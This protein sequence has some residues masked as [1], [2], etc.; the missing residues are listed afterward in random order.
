MYSTNK[1]ISNK[2][3]TINS[4]AVC[5]KYLQYPDETSK[6]QA[7]GGLRLKGQYKQTLKDKPLITVITVVYNNEDTLERCIKSVLEQTYDNIEYIVID[8]GSNDGTLNIIK[9]YEDSIDYFISEP[10]GGI[11]YAMNKG[12]SLVSG[13]YIN[14]MNSDDWF[15]E[16]LTISSI[17]KSTV[18]DLNTIYYGKIMYVKEGKEYRESWEQLVDANIL[19]GYPIPHQSAFVGRNVFNT[20]GIFDTKYKISADF[21]W[22]VKA[23][24]NK[25]SFYNMHCIVANYSIEGISSSDDGWDTGQIEYMYILLINKIIEPKDLLSPKLKFFDSFKN[26]DKDSIIQDLAHINLSKD[27]TALIEECTRPIISIIIPVYNMEIYIQDCLDSLIEQSI[28]NRLEIIIVDDTSTD[29]SVEIINQYTDTYSAITLIKHNTNLGALAARYTGIQQAQGKYFIF[30]DSDDLM[31]ADACEI[32]Y[33]EIESKNADIV[34]GKM[35]WKFDENH[36]FSKKEQITMAY[37]K[38]WHDNTPSKNIRFDTVAAILPLS[39][40]I[41]K[42]SLVKEALDYDIPKISH[43]EDICFFIRIFLKSKTF[44]VSNE[45]VYWRRRRNNSA[46]SGSSINIVVERVLSLL[47]M[48]QQTKVF[49]L[50]KLEQTIIRSQISYIEGISEKIEDSKEKNDA[51]NIIENLKG[52]LNGDLLK[53]YNDLKDTYSIKTLNDVF[54]I[55]QPCLESKKDYVDLAPVIIFIYNRVD[56]LART[57]SALANN[58]LAEETDLYIFSDGTKSAKPDD[59]KKVDEVRKFIKTIKG[60]KSITIQEQKAN[61][62]LTNSLINGI[63]EVSQKHANFIVLED[64][65]LTSPFFLKYMNASLEKYKEEQKVWCI[66]GMA[67]NPEYLEIPEDY[68]YD[69]YFN[70]RNS[71]HGWASWSNRWEKVVWD[72]A[73][74]KYE[75]S[76]YKQQLLFNRGGNDMYPMMQSLF[77]ENIDSW[78][79][80][81]AYTISQNNGISLSPKYSLVTVQESAEGT[82]TESYKKL[83]DNDLSLSLEELTYPDTLKVDQE[84]AK[85]Y[86]ALYENLL[87]K[88]VKGAEKQD[89]IPEVFPET[90]SS[91]DKWHR[92]G[93]LSKKRKIWT[94]GKVISKKIGVYGLLKP[95]TQIVKNSID[96]KKNKNES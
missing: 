79:I 34:M 95:S 77:D 56:V 43:G 27:N 90:A 76:D 29:N 71:S 32:L 44:F 23:K 91:N 24:I 89:S 53:F 67:L 94:V 28:F 39:S 55:T 25:I 14:F 60:F 86:K 63:N 59:S 51:F 78:E 66:N 50:T 87:S 17:I 3:P 69:T 57:I 58:Y 21:E 82:H 48:I 16:D 81:W 37:L 70:Y 88:P 54:D 20:L 36:E 15:R 47:Y 61:I 93:K 83:I 74:I 92:F 12:I 7:E 73:Q 41:Y 33:R 2:K 9:K 8:G 64:D 72:H 96:G 75:L 26:I 45:T 6:R 11:Y 62:G 19:V 35:I 65:L 30:L 42:A 38:Q 52:A 18:L 22:W 4:H 68:L 49:Y 84:I 13:D 85:R 10:D 31:P 1:N 80:R 40:K 46:I 5:N